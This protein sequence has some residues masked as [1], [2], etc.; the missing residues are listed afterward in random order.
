[1]LEP[2]Y[3]VT[4]KCGYCETEFRTSK[5]RSSFKKASFTDT[6]FFCRY[7]SINPDYYIVA[8]CPFCGYAFS[9]NFSDGLSP[10]FRTK[11]ELTVRKNWQG[12]SFGGERSWD[13]ALRTFKLALLCAQIKQEK[14]R[15]AAGLLHHIAWLYREKGDE[16][17]ERRF[18]EL[19]LEA[20]IKVYELE[21]IS[22]NNAR[23][24]YLLGELNRRLGNYNEAVRWFDRVVNDKKILDSAMIRASRDQWAATRQDMLERSQASENAETG[25]P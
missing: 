17:Q 2:L 16:E 3:Q 4:E 9:E 23:L 12:G 20:Y 22:V 10:A 5:V 6:D 11:F 21:G 13:D 8:V 14:D 18:L 24:M 19:A 25:R 1:M 15:V 7:K